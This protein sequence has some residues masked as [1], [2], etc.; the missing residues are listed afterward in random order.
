M[1]I[2]SSLNGPGGL[3][4]TGISSRS[5]QTSSFRDSLLVSEGGT[6]RGLQ[7]PASSDDQKYYH[8]KGVR[9]ADMQATNNSIPE[10]GLP[11][12]DKHDAPLGVEAVSDQNDAVHVN[13][14]QR[15]GCAHAAQPEDAAARLPPTEPA[16]PCSPVKAAIQSTAD[17]AP[18]ARL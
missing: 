5:H 14:H 17:L 15:H 11:G 12:A 2:Y 13:A 6:S 4:T 1:Q 16:S 8:A 10:R 7:W 9:D 18:R 3:K